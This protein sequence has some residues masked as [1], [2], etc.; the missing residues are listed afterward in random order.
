MCHLSLSECQ[1]ILKNNMDLNNRINDMLS[2]ENLSYKKSIN[3]VNTV[4]LINDVIG[5][6]KIK[7]LVKKPLVNLKV[8]T[9]YGCH[10]IRPNEIGR[11][12][13]SENPQKM[14]K[15]IEAIGAEPRDYPEKLDCCGSMIN[16]NLPESALTKTGQKL[17]AVQEQGFDVFIDVCPWC[18][19]MF[20]SKQKKAGETVASKLGIPVLYLTQILGLSFGI[21]R[22]KLGLNLNLSPVEKIKIGGN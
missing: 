14:E 2:S 21:D 8:A 20:D 13:D 1:N 19:R 12:V 3:I 11:P 18:H 5:I 15:I 16:T 7:N 17:V 10:L 6:E 22:K 4:D 9:H